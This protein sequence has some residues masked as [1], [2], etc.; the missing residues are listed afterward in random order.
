MKAI[1]VSLALITFVIPCLADD[2]SLGSRVTDYGQAT[3]VFNLSRKRLDSMPQW[4]SIQPNPPLSPRKAQ[5]V[6]FKKLREL[7]PKEPKWRLISISLEPVDEDSEGKFKFWIYVV[8]Y[9]G[10]SG[11][12]FGATEPFDIVVTM[13]GK[14]IDP[15]IE[16]H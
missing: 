7:V 10:N 11:M 4:T 5:E 16:R 13:D 14:A 2:D 8:R 15:E 1:V 6:A 12:V 9:E 3:Y